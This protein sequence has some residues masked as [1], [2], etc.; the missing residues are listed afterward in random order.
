MGRKHNRFRLGQ[1]GN[2]GEKYVF[3]KIG[4]GLKTVL[5]LSGVAYLAGFIVVN[6]RFLGWGVGEGDLVDARYI[7]AGAIFLFVA[8][9]TTLFPYLRG[10]ASLNA[11]HH[12]IA[13]AYFS[14]PLHLLHV[15]N[16]R[17]I[18]RWFG[19]L[20]VIVALF[21]ALLE[22][23]APKGRQWEIRTFVR[24]FTLWYVGSIV[25]SRF[26]VVLFNL[27]YYWRAKMLLGEGS[28]WSNFGKSFRRS[29]V[30]SFKRSFEFSHGKPPTD[31]EVKVGLS[32]SVLSGIGPEG[33]LASALYKG[34]A[35]FLLSA[36]TFG[37]FVYP[38][39]PASIGGGK[40]QTVVLLLSADKSTGLAELGVPG[41]RVHMKSKPGKE[42]DQAAGF[43]LLTEPLPLLA[44]TSEGYFLLISSAT[45][46]EV[47]K[48][49]STIVD[50][51]SY[52][53]QPGVSGSRPWFGR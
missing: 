39:L 50:A 32:E 48:I 27:N 14:E 17:F 46:T 3:E 10:L 40:S 37:A 19:P 2:P 25:F 43:Q 44:K 51:V 5:G 41:K 34:V 26:A 13:G 36:T 31:E 9:P 4:K 7:A 1:N 21:V 15:A 45:G 8:I 49:P 33:F 53:G 6:T 12:R 38:A 18:D 11:L 24:V 35:L 23:Y 52:G 29:F 28:F 22:F 42:I 20:L 16:R 30:T 47:V